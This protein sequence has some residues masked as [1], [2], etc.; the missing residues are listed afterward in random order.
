M[1]AA[2]MAT[3]ATVEAARSTRA[4]CRA[5]PAMKLTR[6]RNGSRARERD[7]EAGEPRQVGVGERAER[8][9]SRRTRLRGRPRT[10][11]RQR[12]S[13]VPDERGVRP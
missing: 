10:W 9:A 12:R 7:A 3:M 13:R 5:A 11:V 1:I 4:F 8:P 6:E 2:A